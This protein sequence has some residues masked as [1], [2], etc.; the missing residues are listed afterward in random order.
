MSIKSW[1]ARDTQPAMAIKVEVKT[2]VHRP[3]ATVN[4]A[5][6]TRITGIRTGIPIPDS[7]FA[8]P[9]GYKI[10]QAGAPGSS[11]MQGGPGM[12]APRPR[13]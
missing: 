9:P 1:I 4:Q 7:L 2:Q 5:Q 3:N 6:T 11:T 13:P 12:S 8:V 10:V